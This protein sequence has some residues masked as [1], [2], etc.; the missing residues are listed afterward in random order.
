MRKIK[1]KL[2]RPPKVPSEVK[3]KLAAFRFRDEERE[4]YQVAADKSG[5]SLSE[6]VRQVLNHAVQVDH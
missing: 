2:G 1:P 6:W 5:L 3:G 4:A